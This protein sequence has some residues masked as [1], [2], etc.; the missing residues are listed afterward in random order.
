MLGRPPAFDVAGLMFSPPQQVTV[1][2]L[3]RRFGLSQCMFDF[4]EGEASPLSLKPTL[5]GPRSQL[6]TESSQN[7]K[8]WGGLRPSMLQG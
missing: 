7:E 6:V 2:A 5:A 3:L 1:M 4:F 8:S